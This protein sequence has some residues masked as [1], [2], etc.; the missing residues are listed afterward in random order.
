M[1]KVRDFKRV[2]HL[3]YSFDIEPV[4]RNSIRTST[5]RAVIQGLCHIDTN[6]N[7]IR[8][9]TFIQTRSTNAH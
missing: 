9:V 1:E 3:V 4:S 5:E 2:L 6:Q 7:Q 8:T